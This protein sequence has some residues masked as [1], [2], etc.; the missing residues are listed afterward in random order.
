[1]KDHILSIIKD[2]G[3]VGAGG[4]G[5]PTHIKL[6]AAAEYLIVNGAECEPLLRANQELLTKY[7]PILWDALQ[8]M[9][10]SLG[11]KQVIFAV[12]KKYETAVNQL[13]ASLPAVSK[14]RI[15]LL[16]D[17]YPAGDEHILVY[18]VTGRIVP[19]G[20]IPL[21]V[22]CVVINVET[23]YN[24]HRALEGKPVTRKFVTVTGAVNKPMTVAAPIGTG[25]S[26]LIQ[27]AGGASVKEYAVISG[28]PM[29]GYLAPRGEVVT[30]TTGGIILLPSEHPLVRYK[31]TSLTNVVLR[32]RAVCC[33][34]R[35]CT[36][37]CPRYLQGHNLEPHKIMRALASGNIKQYMTN[38]YLCSECGVCDRFACPMDLAP[39]Q[40][41]KL[42]KEEMAKLGI[43]SPHRES[44]LV[45]RTMRDIHKVPS[46]RLVMRLGLERYNLPAPVIDTDFVPAEVRVLLQQHLGKPALPLVK[47]GDYVEAGQLLGDIPG[48]TSLGARIHAG[49]SGIVHSIDNGI[50]I[51][52][53]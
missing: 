18:E 33:Q 10:A 25:Y 13:K 51:L 14:Y 30:K 39:R 32:A 15:H 49:I 12:K 11:L 45:V 38:A 26:D 31:N 47:P 20:G 50:L 21:K 23:L 2:A 24:I 52:G 8:T 44:P 37:I 34:C 27:L 28:G 36:D 3:V 43:A 46:Q 41:N 5:F 19:E 16:D 17:F 22:G 42:F 40:V 53:R 4:A 1:M 29:M 48:D 7:S 9:T 6:N 35:A